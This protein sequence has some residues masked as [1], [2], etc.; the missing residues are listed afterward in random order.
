MQLAN[1]IDKA[2]E[3][4][5]LNFP[6]SVFADAVQFLTVLP[7]YAGGDDVL[8]GQIKPILKDK[9]ILLR[10]RC[11]DEALVRQ[12]AICR[13][14]IAAAWDDEA[15]GSYATNFR[16][17]LEKALVSYQ[18][19]LEETK[20][21]DIEQAIKMRHD[22]QAKV[23]AE[24]VAKRSFLSGNHAIRAGFGSSPVSPN[25]ASSNCA[26]M[27]MVPSEAMAT[28]RRNFEGSTAKP[29]PTGAL[30]SAGTRTALQRFPPISANYV[31]GQTAL[32]SEANYIANTHSPASRS[33][34]SVRGVIKEQPLDD[35][36]LNSGDG[37]NKP[38]GLPKFVET[39]ST[40]RCGPTCEPV[41]PAPRNLGSC[42]TRQPT[43]GFQVPSRYD[44]SNKEE[45]ITISEVNPR[46]SLIPQG[47]KA[48]TPIEFKKNLQ[49]TQD[50][51]GGQSP[52]TGNSVGP[53]EPERMLD[54]LESASI[55]A[56]KVQAQIAEGNLRVLER[57]IADQQRREAEIDL[58]MQEFWAERKRC[59]ER[60]HNDSKLL[61]PTRYEQLRQDLRKVLR[62]SIPCPIQEEV[63]R[64]RRQHLVEAYSI[65]TGSGNLNQHVPI[66]L[67]AEITPGRFATI[68][69][70]YHNYG[71]GVEKIVYAPKHVGD[72]RKL[73]T[74]E[75]QYFMRCRVDADET[76]IVEICVRHGE[77]R[78]SD[79]VTTYRGKIEYAFVSGVE[80]IR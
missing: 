79:A 5:D 3:G 28:A 45:I 66:D 71:N 22:A 34:G 73:V 74:Y 19:D 43:G 52:P 46:Q 67:V 61:L 10:N 47:F 65:A 41:R 70:I 57:K 16:P 36:P 68:L 40:D 27:N 30:D 12:C 63:D 42:I 75:I 38:Q 7:N 62:S 55:N 9:L 11:L 48:A 24:I 26:S 58:A 13:N 17:L 37:A 80:I 25:L 64:L 32:N 33:I 15:F 1:V 60:F 23:A 56:Y 49:S 50:M 4:I 6:L 18:E 54:E 53:H 31:G 44:S 20:K 51:I 59:L 14:T 39:I 21:R 78:T 2:F 8:E 69:G 35:G 77:L 29:V 72:R 76:D